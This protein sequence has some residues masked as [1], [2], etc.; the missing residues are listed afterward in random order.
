MNSAPTA[1][2]QEDP[3][4][5]A[6]DLVE[7]AAA[8]QAFDLDQESRAMRDRYGGRTIGQSCL[9]ARRLLERDVPF[10]TINYQGWDTHD[11][12]YTRLKEGFTGARTPVGLIPSLDQ[13]LSALMDDLQQSGLLDE[14]L[15]VVMGEF[16]RT[17]KINTSGG[18]DHWPRA[19]SVLLAGA[20]I[21]GQIIGAS[22][23][24]AESPHDRPVTPADL[25]ATVFTLLGI[26]PKHEFRTSD[27]RPIQASRDGVVLQELV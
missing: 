24:T 16:G 8:R 27:G 2:A 19:F 26:D 21:E 6:Y 5:Q 12:A 23:R 7:S 10:L 4:R 11:N 18:R 14:T 13:A 3:W 22:D 20:G 9:L 25:A 1:L 15:I 17:P